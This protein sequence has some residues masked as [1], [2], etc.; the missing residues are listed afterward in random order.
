ML[1]SNSVSDLEH[2]Q[3]RR[4]MPEG[5]HKEELIHF[6]IDEEPY[7]TKAHELTP[8][9]LIAEFAG[10]DPA[11]Y[12]LVQLRGHEQISYQDRPDAEIVMEDHDKFITA[13]IGPTPVS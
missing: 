9:Q 1:I 6:H 10:L 5:N 7:D 3:R 8:R 2:R 13:S 4:I 11:A 12:Y